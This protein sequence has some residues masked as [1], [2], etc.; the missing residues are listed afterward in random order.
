MILRK[1]RKHRILAAVIAVCMMTACSLTI[2]DP[3]FAAEDFDG[4]TQQNGTSYKKVSQAEQPVL[5][6]FG[7]SVTKGDGLQKTWKAMTQE[8][9]DAIT[10]DDSATK[11][12][13]DDNAESYWQKDTYTLKDNRGVVSKQEAAGLN[14]TEIAASL[15][16]SVSPTSKVQLTVK[17]KN[18]DSRSI[19]NF[20]AGK[21][22]AFLDTDNQVAVKAV[23]AL[24]QGKLPALR[25]GQET[26]DE[27]NTGAWSEDVKEVQ[28]DA[29]TS[30]TMVPSVV[31]TATVN[32]KDYDYTIGDIIHAGQYETTYYYD[33]GGE[34]VTASLKGI[35]LET[36]LLSK[37]IRLKSG[38]FIR[39]MAKTAD[40][41]TAYQTISYNEMKRCFV[42]YE[43]TES[44]GAASQAISSRTEFCLY[45]PDTRIVDY[46][47]IDAETVPAVPSAFKAAGSGHDQVTL[48][49]SRVADADG[50][51]IYNAATKKTVSLAKEKTSYT[52]KKLTTGKSYSYKIR[53]YKN[54]VAGKLYSAY[55]GNKTAKPVLGKT[56]IKKIKK[57]SAKSLTLTWSRVAGASGYKILYSTNKKFKKGKNKTVTIKKGKTVKKTLKGLK[58]GKRYYVKI[59]AYKTVKGKKVYGAYSSVKKKKL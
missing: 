7:E 11:F 47:G 40:N 2:L 18:G 46:W 57:N 15:G 3:A 19:K 48:S 31:F 41:G 51:E 37:N 4:K 30:A 49:W 28:F 25:I 55:S 45:A 24:Q 6:I 52:E 23:L 8:Q 43:G 38:D 5:V 32:G 27:V 16:V 56:K 44:I 42:A 20:F 13:G 22:Y 21:R 39:T 26:K 59:R 12:F 54:T 34:Q 17:S 58:K 36:L 1:N 9:M 14:L 10:D 33:R 50:Y 53:A 35:P 29:I